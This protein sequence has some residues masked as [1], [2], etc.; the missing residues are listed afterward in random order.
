MLWQLEPRWKIL[1]LPV[2]RQYLGSCGKG[3]FVRTGGHPAGSVDLRADEFFLASTQQGW[4]EALRGGEL[5]RYDTKSAEFVPF[6]SGIS[7][8]SVSFSRDG[9]WVTY[10]SFPEGTLWKSKS[11]GSQRIQLTNPPLSVRLPSWSPDGQQIVFYA[12]S[13]GPEKPKL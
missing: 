5:A 10:V 7:A 13:S 3:E 8:D 11:D 2:P 9:Q 1:R 6:L 4:Q 12:F